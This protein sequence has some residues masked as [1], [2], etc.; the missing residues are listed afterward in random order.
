MTGLP[1]IIRGVM[2][3]IDAMAAVGSGASA[4]WVH[5]NI[6][7]GAS[8][9]SVLRNVVATLR[10]NHMMTEIFYSG[11]IRRGTDAIKALGL[12]ANCVF[13][14]TETPLWALCHSQQA[15]L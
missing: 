14:D 7:G 2:S 13:L 6:E 9:I 5:S 12:G 3:G 15:G 8:P 4:V 1:V 11:G 10:G